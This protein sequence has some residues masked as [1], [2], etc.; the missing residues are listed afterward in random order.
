M[1]APHIRTLSALCF[2]TAFRPLRYDISNGGRDMR[3]AVRY[4][5][6][7]L[8]VRGWLGADGTMEP[9]EVDGTAGVRLHLSYFL[10]EGGGDEREPHWNGVDAAP[11]PMA[12]LVNVLG[13]AAFLPALAFFPVL[14]F[15]GRE[16]L[17]VFRFPALGVDIAARRV[18]PGEEAAL[19]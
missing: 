1:Y 17:C 3:S 12:E 19:V 7:S 8:G 2:G 5:A 18:T 14:Y 13:R 15:S 4:C 11:Q 10:A 6:E 16:G 9:A